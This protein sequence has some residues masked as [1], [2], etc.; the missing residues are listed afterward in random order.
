M[1]TRCR[2]KWF[3]Q[4]CILNFFFFSGNNLGKMI[5]N[6]DL[7]QV[8]KVVAHIIISFFKNEEV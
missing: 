3:F 1:Q 2:N 7:P 6:A 8:N 5:P 4:E